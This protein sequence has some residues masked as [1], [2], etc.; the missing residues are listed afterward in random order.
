MNEELREKVI[1]G[2]ESIVNDDWMW[3]KAD[4][5]TGICKDAL[6]LLKAQ[7]PR[8]LTLEEVIQHYSLPLV[9]VDD[10]CAQ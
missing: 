8:V 1:R 6:A 2:L 9:F 4:Y 5:Y 10:F 7:E 3:K